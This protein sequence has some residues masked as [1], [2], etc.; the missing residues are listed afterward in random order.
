V[1]PNDA[2]AWCDTTLDD[3]RMLSQYPGV[4]AIG[5]IGLDFYRRY[6]PPDR[7]TELLVAQLNLAAEVD[8]PVILHCRQANS[9]LYR[10]VSDWTES[11]HKRNSSL[12][13]KPG[14]LHAF[15][16]SLE[17]AAAWN[18]LGFMLGIGG[19]VTYHN[20][21][22]RKELVRRVPLEWIVLETDAPFLSPQPFRGR[23]NEPAHIRIIAESVA[24]LKNIELKDV[25]RVTGRNAVTLFG[26]SY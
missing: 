22:D 5:E 19:P 21:P 10:I 26:W 18:R 3:L 8:L 2:A 11:L 25:V 17:D 24:N 4:V 1:H 15:D 13:N 6:T 7:Q 16:G 12:R 14:V 23:R 20:A 9:E